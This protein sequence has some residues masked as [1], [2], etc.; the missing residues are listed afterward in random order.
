MFRI[1]KRIPRRRPNQAELLSAIQYYSQRKK[2]F[3]DFL[4]LLAYDYEIG[5]INNGIKHLLRK[6]YELQYSFNE[7]KRN[8]YVRL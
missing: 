6:E 7:N 8:R 5:F 2:S 4:K 3:E 1:C